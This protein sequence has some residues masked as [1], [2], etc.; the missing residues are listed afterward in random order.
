MAIRPAAMASVNGK[1]DQTEVDA[2][3]EG[4]GAAAGSKAAPPLDIHEEGG[5]SRATDTHPPDSRTN[6]GNTPAV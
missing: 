6:P 1:A 5:G 3:N 4:P 2:A